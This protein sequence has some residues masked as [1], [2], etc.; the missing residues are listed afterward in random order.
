MAK[1]EEHV[2]RGT[3]RVAV[4][5]RTTS[6][7]GWGPVLGGVGWIDPPRLTAC[8]SSQAGCAMGCAFCA[9]ARHSAAT[10]S[11]TLVR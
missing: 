4:A 8:I 5:A 7:L 6:D 10:T 2:S 1:A 11:N 3:A 9:T